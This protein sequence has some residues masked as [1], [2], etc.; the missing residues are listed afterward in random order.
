MLNEIGLTSK[1]IVKTSQTAMMKQ[2][3]KYDKILNN[4]N[5]QD[6]DF[7]NIYNSIQNKSAYNN[8]IHTTHFIVRIRRY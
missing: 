1:L 5:I 4:I 8:N 7:K 2:V 3:S 6:S